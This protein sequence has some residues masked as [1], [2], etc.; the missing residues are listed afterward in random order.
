M[1]VFFHVLRV[2]TETF[3]KCGTSFVVDLCSVFLRF[4][5]EEAVFRLSQYPGQAVIQ[6]GKEGIVSAFRF[7]F[8][9][10]AAERPADASGVQD[11]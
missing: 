4:K 1:S 2:V 3:F 7:L 11:P 8:F 6:I 10:R 5:L 9:F